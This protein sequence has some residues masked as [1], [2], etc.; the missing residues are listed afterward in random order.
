MAIKF[1]SIRTKT[2]LF[3]VGVFGAGVL[4]LIFILP[5]INRQNAVESAI[6]NAESTVAQ[7]MTLRSYYTKNVVGPVKSKSNL[8]VTHD[9]RIRENAIPLPA[10]MILDLS[11]LLTDKNGIQLKIYS[12]FPF[13][14]RSDRVLDDFAID[15]LAYLE[16]N[17]EGRFVRTDLTGG[18]ELVRV[19]IADK[20]VNENCVTCHNNHPLTPKKGWKLGDVRGALEVIV[21]IHNQMKADRETSFIII[22]IIGL[23]FTIIVAS[24][25]VFLRIAIFK[26]IR[27]VAAT[28]LKIA[29]GNLDAKIDIKS[30][31][32]MGQLAGSFNV[33]TISLKNT[34]TDLENLKENLEHQVEKRTEELT[35]SRNEAESATHAKSDFLANM[36]HEIR[37]PMNGIIGM[38]ELLLNTEMT[39]RQHNYANLIERSADSLLFIIN[40]IL[41]FSKIEAGK[42]ELELIPFDL[43]VTVESVAH[44]LLVQVEQAGIELLV[45]CS[46]EMPTDVIGDPMRIRQILINL[47]SNAIK[48]TRKGHVMIDVRCVTREKDKAFF[49][50]S[51]EDTGI[52]VGQDKI[53]HIFDKFS[54]EDTSITRKYG[55]TGLGLAICKQLAQLM[56]GDITVE[57]NQGEGSVF[58]L[59]IPLALDS[60][61]GAGEERPKANLKGLNVLIVDDNTINRQIYTELL[62]YWHINCDAVASGREALQSLRSAAGTKHSYHAALLDFFMPEMSGDVLAKIIKS[63]PLIQDTLLIMLTSGS[64]P[65]A[66]KQMEEL[67]FSAYLEKPVRSGELMD[68]LAIAWA[69]FKN[70]KRGGMISQQ[71]LAEL[72]AKENSK[73]LGKSDGMFKIEARILLVEDNVVNQEV[74][75]E[76]LQQFGCSVELAKNG[77]EAVQMFK[78]NEYDL[79][80]MDCQMPVM[81]GLEA[82]KLIREYEKSKNCHTKIIA[83]TA[84]AMRG[85][86]EHC[87]DAGMDD[88]LTKPVRQKAL[89]DILVKY[90]AH[91][92]IS[93]IKDENKEVIEGKIAAPAEKESKADKPVFSISGTLDFVG[94]NV[95]RMKRLIEIT[96]EDSQ[97]QMEQLRKSIEKEDISVTERAAHTLKGQAANL[98]ADSF[99]DVAKRIEFAAKEGDMKFVHDMMANFEVEYKVLTKALMEI[100]W[101][102][103]K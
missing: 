54:Q 98:G 37:T 53:E 29:K 62:G 84:N 70:G 23:M 63:D 97:K 74:V 45:R 39:S 26:P 20:M 90:C 78:K 32:E 9:Y 28:A 36:S 81:D 86:R 24:T 79:V 41:D 16:T 18:K 34:I 13:P 15:A 57:S 95:K 55:G 83:M 4:A 61:R 100:D 87:L 22:S 19:A 85:D 94:G 71:V 12:A 93:F 65:G 27:V 25:L 40:D 67:G 5:N 82:T 103:V 69:G 7:Y 8:L 58:T 17:P 102:L 72:K 2:I 88:Y 14:N 73:Y 43:Q 47:M 60:S 75:I 35:I 52:G 10:T 96:L 77:C 1:N 59:A 48:F 68:T 76:N 3:F 33:M 99:R 42:L 91:E 50:F 11:A 66:A 80:F 101:D 92:E 64:R 51:V 30:D 49:K 89:L 56:N 31:D 46:P 38:V 44:S 6:N 21:P